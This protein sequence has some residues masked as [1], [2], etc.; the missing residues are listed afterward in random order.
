MVQRKETE[1]QEWGVPKL[2]FGD[3]KGQNCRAAIFARRFF[4]TGKIAALLFVWGTIAS[5][6]LL[7]F[8]RKESVI[9]DVVRYFFSLPYTCDL[10]EAPMDAE[11]NPTLAVLFFSLR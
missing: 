1:F 5:R 3:E 4:L 10:V 2:E 11:I 8:D 7:A 9:E 6:K